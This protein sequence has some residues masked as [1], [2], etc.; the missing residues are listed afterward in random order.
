MISNVR[1]RIRNTSLPKSQALLPLIEAII[2]SIDAI[3]DIK[4]DISDGSIQVRIIRQPSLPFADQGDGESRNFTPIDGFEVVDNGIGFTEANFNAFNEAD[5]QYKEHRGGKGMG[6]FIWLKAFQR[7]EV[8]SVF[9]KNDD[10]LRRKFN[11]TLNSP[12]G[13]SEHT[14]TPAPE[15]EIEQTVF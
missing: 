2:N 1:G 8:E 13:I 10:L 5:T 4:S 9:R 7:V 6:R 11:F 14:I 12:D 15:G 3:E